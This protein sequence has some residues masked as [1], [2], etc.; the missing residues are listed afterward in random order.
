MFNSFRPPSSSWNPDSDSDSNEESEESSTF[1]N[2]PVARMFHAQS[3]SMS[4]PSLARN[5][6]SNSLHSIDD[7]PDAEDDARSVQ[8]DESGWSIT[9]SDLLHEIK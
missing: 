9:S 5:H 7:N 4:H 8:S 6:R 1:A 3:S 2:T